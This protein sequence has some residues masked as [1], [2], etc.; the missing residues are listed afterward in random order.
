[1]ADEG[2]AGFAIGGRPIGLGHPAY[3]VAE[4]SANHRQDLACARDLVRAAAEAGADAVK[5]QTYTADTLT[6]DHR[7]DIF[8]IGKGTAWADAILHDLY[9]QAEMPWEWHGELMALAQSLG[10]H[11][12]SSPFDASAVAFLERLGVPA[13]KVAAFEL[14]DLPLL[15]HIAR[16]GRPVIL[17]TGMATLEEIGEAMATIR[18]VREVPVA[19]L[20]TCSAYPAPPEEMDLRAIPDLAA[21]FGVV[22]GLSDHTLGIA[23][24]VAAVTLGACIVEKH[25]TLSRAAGGPDAGFSLEPAEF[26]A[27]VQAVRTA[28][29]ALGSV[30]YGPAP[31]ER[32]SLQFRRSL[33]AVED[34]RAGEVLT[35]INVRCIR[36]AAGLHPRHLEE[37]LGRRAR[38]DIARGTPLS[39]ELLA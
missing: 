28:E 1:M 2:P 12:F 26:A 34:I 35:A 29:A 17:S 32:A 10:L 15:R 31:G 23:V 39:W 4:L 16:T 30:R 3:L 8:R 13:Y 5:L 7:G 19:L 37:V 9:R 27:M 24:P 11:C 33:F 22:A 36:P 25:L 20:R 21:R 18:A 6:L 38:R 14:V